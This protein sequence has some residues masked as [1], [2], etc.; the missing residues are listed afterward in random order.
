VI[1]KLFNRAETTVCRAALKTG[2]ASDLIEKLDLLTLI[3]YKERVA[4]G[5]DADNFILAW[6]PVSGF[7]CSR[8]IRAFLN[9]VQGK[10][11]L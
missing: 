10:W 11:L 9:G 3:I 7:T 1:K 4:E 6:P 5:C 8:A 2:N